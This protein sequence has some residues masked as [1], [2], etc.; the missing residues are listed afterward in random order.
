M[1]IRLY[2][3]GT[4]AKGNDYPYMIK[5]RLVESLPDISSLSI[6]DGKFYYNFEALQKKGYIETAEVVHTEKRP[7]KTLYSITQEGRL[8][9]EDDIYNSFKKFTTIKDLYISIY[10]LDF[11]DTNKVAVFFEETIKQ[12]KKRRQTFEAMKRQSEAAGEKLSK[13]VA[14]ITDHSFKT[15]D[16]NIE[17]ME[18]L[19]ELIKNYE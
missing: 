11:V 1:S 7:D 3:L 13:S 17:W 4:L 10:L 19:L 2:I 15:M 9:L 5:K 6:S 8:A 16:F 12:E 14:F 18:K